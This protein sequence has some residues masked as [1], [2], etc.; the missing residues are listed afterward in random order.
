LYVTDGSNFHGY[1]RKI[2]PQ[3]NVSTYEGE[4]VSTTLPWSGLLSLAVDANDNL[5]ALN[6]YEIYKI[7]APHDVSVFVGGQQ[8]YLDGNGS[9][10][11]FNFTGYLSGSPTGNLFFADYDSSNQHQVR[12]I[13]PNGDVSTFTLTDNTSYDDILNGFLWIFPI[14]VDQNGN[15]YITSNK[16]NVIKKIDPQGN[17]TVF[18]GGEAGFA[19]GKGTLATF[20]GISGLY[21]DHSGNIFVC[22][23]NNNAIRKITPDGTVTTIAGTGTAGFLD[24]DGPSAKFD[25]PF[26]LVVASD[27]VVYVSDYNNN[28]I[29][30]IEYK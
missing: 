11:K 3:G 18:A 7:V 19:D 13:T 22:D 21:A 4:T 26:H 9:N 16:S 1:I 24:G 14:T 28:R 27:G 6:D 15:L 29:R 23:L 20:N 30:K 8:G 12:M 25:R 5:Y 2:D 17:V 10:A